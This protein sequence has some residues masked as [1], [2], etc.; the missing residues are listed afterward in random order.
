MARD[1]DWTLIRSFLAVLRDGSLSAAARR[2]RLAQP[3]LGRHIAALEEDVGLALFTRAPAGLVPTAAA[4]AMR[5]MAEA[6]EQA[7]AALLRAAEGADDPARG[8]VRITASE[9]MGA[10]VLPP[11]LAEL[12]RRHPGLVLELALENRAGDLLRR[13]ADIAVRMFRPRQEAL[14]ARRIGRVGLGLYAHR[15]YVARHG[16]PG[17]VAELGRFHVIGFDRDD[18][19]ARAVAE[20]TLPIDRG[21]FRVRSDSDLA[22]AALLRAGLGIGA[23]QHLLAAEV[24]ELV[25]VLAAEVQLGL[26]MWLAMHEDQRGNAAVRA[27]FEVLGE[28]L[29]AFLGK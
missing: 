8:T 10:Q 27:A 24:P 3:T 4:L 19:S 16:M 18:G 12:Q 13:D 11:I 15:D 29:L 22:Q 5:P 28:G 23:M 20:G 21:L 1:P 17:S 7:A 2:L 25:P 9:V 26:E 6:M 14:L